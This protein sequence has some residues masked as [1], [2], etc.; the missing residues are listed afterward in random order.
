MAARERKL[1]CTQADLYDVGLSER[2][3]SRVAAF[4]MATSAIAA[5]AAAAFSAAV[6]FGAEPSILYEDAQI[7]AVLETLYEE[8]FNAGMNT[9]AIA[10]QLICTATLTGNEEL[11]GT[12]IVNVPDGRARHRIRFAL[13]ERSGGVR[14]WAYPWIEIEEPGGTLLEQEIASEEYLSRVQAV[15][16]DAAAVLGQEA[17]QNLRRPWAQYYASEDEWRLDA[18]LSSVAHCDAGLADLT[19]E[20]L[21]RQL[22]MADFHPFGKALRDRCEELYEEIFRWGLARGMEAPTVEE[23]AEYQAG[24]PPE[25]RTCKG[26]LALASTCG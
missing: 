10:G 17:G 2:R 5:F 25:Q 23:Y 12:T 19:A 26:R 14:V 11:D 22:A 1:R 24:L 7:D 16:A 15:L 21:N 20:E 4:T 6:A 8:C 13:A 9:E 3:R 18:H